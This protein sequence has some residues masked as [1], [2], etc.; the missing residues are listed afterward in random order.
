MST[1]LPPAVGKRDSMQMVQRQRK[2][3]LIT[4]AALT[5]FV[6]LFARSSWAFERPVHESVEWVGIGVIAIAILGRVWCSMYL[7]GRKKRMVVRTGPYSIVR[8]PLYVFSVIGA[9]GVGLCTGSVVIA[10]ALALVVWLVFD[11]VIRR[12]ERYLSENLGE[13]YLAYLGSTPRWIPAF[14]RWSGTES[15]EVRPD[16]MWRTLRDALWFLAAFPLL[17]LV[18]EMQIHHWLPE[19][20]RLP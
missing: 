18:E 8:N 11:G 15:V 12:E 5:G 16:L 6:L 3:V 14:S 20:L 4:A 10:F 19:L 2:A 7:G 1:S 17:E 9:A 13:P